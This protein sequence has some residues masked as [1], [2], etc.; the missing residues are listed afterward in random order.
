MLNMKRQSGVTLVELMV[1]ASIGLILLLG[2][3]TFM[4]NNLSSNATTRKSAALNQE[5][6]AIMS[7]LSRDIRR[8]GYWGSPTFTSGAL[9]GVG[10]GSTYSNPFSTINTATAGCILYSY[11]K[12]GNGTQDSAEQ[13][14]VLF[15]NGVVKMR[16]NISATTYDCTAD[17]SNSWDD[18]SDPKNTLITGLT[19]TKTDSAP[20]YMSGSTG[21]NI[22]VRQIQITLTGQ[23]KND[24]TV[25]QTLTETVRVENDLFS[26]A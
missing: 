8:S 15:D 3:S 20:I 23:L 25:T 11:D 6:R 7:L 12:N 24:A 18:L 13:Y 19:F 5:L 26:P 1:A 10:A 17:S 21:P 2:M 16:T 9:T 22:K 4:A 14:G